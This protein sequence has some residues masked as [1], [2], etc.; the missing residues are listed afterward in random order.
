MELQFDEAPE[1][2]KLLVWDDTLLGQYQD[3]TAEIP[4]GK[5]VEITE[6]N[7]GNLEFTA[8]PGSVYLVQGQWEQGTAEYGFH[9]GKSQ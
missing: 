9:V 4:E 7:E 5:N 8:Q 3:G 6:N 1:S 2:V